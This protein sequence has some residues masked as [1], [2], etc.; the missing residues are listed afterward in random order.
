MVVE[1]FHCIVKSTLSFILSCLSSPA[2]LQTIN[3]TD[4]I[5]LKMLKAIIELKAS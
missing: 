2:M 3:K 5:R 4:I 1:C